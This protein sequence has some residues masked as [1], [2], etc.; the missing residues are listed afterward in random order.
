[1]GVIS[2]R[3][4]LNAIETELVSANEGGQLNSE[5]KRLL[6]LVQSPSVHEGGLGAFAQGLSLYYSDEIIAGL[7]NMLGTDNDLIKALNK[8]Q[9][10]RGQPALDP[11]E[12]SLARQRRDVG[13]FKEESPVKAIGYELGG[14]VIPALASRGGTL[15]SSLATALA[16]GGIAGSGSSEGGVKD[17]L[18]GALEGGAFGVG[19]TGLLKGGGHLLK[20]GWQAALSPGPMRRG[21]R[22]A[23]EM[24][25]DAIESDTGNITEAGKLVAIGNKPVTLADVGPNTRALT[26]AA[27][28]LPGSGKKKIRSFLEERDKGMIFRLTDDLKTAFGKRGRFFPEFKSMSQARAARGGKIYRRANQRIIP[29]SSDLTELFQRPAMKSAINEAYK[30]AGN[31]GVKLPML[32]V[33]DVGRLVD[34]NGFA[35]KGVQ[36]KFLHY[37]K[38]GLDDKV[39]TAVPSQGIGRTQKAGIQ[40]VRHSLLKI[41]DRE[42]KT[43]KIARNY[44][45]G[46]TAALNSM[47]RGR[48]FLREDPD[49]LAFDINLMGRSEKEAFRVGAMQGLMD[50]IEGGIES[51][52]IA[53]NLIKRARNKKLIRSTFDSGEKGTQAYNNF[54][55]NLMTEVDMKTTSSQVL[56]NSA[57][58]ARQEA[59]KGLRTGA[60][61]SVPPIRGPFETAM[62]FLRANA[63]DIT[64]IQLKAATERIAQIMTTQDKSAISN[65]LKQ[66]SSP[67]G[68][69]VFLENLG[70]AIPNVSSRIL[71]PGAVG[72]VSGGNKPRLGN[73]LQ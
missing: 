67:T 41:M 50:Q 34:S 10:G 29:M 61:K 46:E 65:M 64:D 59:I 22:Q 53:R 5:G 12:L 27:A 49:E 56:G 48:G 35:V 51:A 66:L 14:A 8:I 43:Y 60:Q 17:R 72:I 52:N 70:Q 3:A 71:S 15:K 69:R 20:K 68:T 40:N 19:T 4:T 2:A 57:T 38:M 18:Q 31:D 63:D 24:A 37:L 25:R 6:K 55:R 9:K 54:M 33:N 58:A 1:M 62:N 7:S 39:F 30:I 73:L 13:K 32:R 28:I 47:K 44:W 45:A 36:T 16:T 42:N 23:D 21:Q 11:Y 26:D